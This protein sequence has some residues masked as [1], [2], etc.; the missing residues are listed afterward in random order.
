MTKPSR[1]RRVALALAGGGAHSAFTWGVLSYLLDDLRDEV[2][3]VALCGT[4]GGA[5]NAA[6][7]AYGL[8]FGATQREANARKL[9]DQFWIRTSEVAALS[10]NPYQHVPNPFWWGIGCWRMW[11]CFYEMRIVWLTAGSD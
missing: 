2:E 8:G 11:K 10:A 9:L 1:R 7:A 5:M 3:I 4:S 6:V